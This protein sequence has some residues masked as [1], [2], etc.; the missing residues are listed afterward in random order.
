MTYTK[1]KF[2]SKLFICNECSYNTCKNSL[3]IKHLDTRK[4]KILTNTYKNT[5]ADIEKNSMYIC[6]CGKEYKHRQSLYTHKKKCDYKENN[7]NEKTDN[8]IINSNENIELKELI[9]KLLIDNADMKKEN[10]KL[11]NHI[12]EIVEGR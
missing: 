4:H 3:Y 11:I 8:K 2:N 7:V 1:N 5:D 6:C 12:V 10:Q 9:M